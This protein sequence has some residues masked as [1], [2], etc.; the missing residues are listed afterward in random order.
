MVV[1][2]VFRD[3]VVGFCGGV[4]WWW[5]VIGWG[6]LR[7]VLQSGSIMVQVLMGLRGPTESSLTRFAAHDLFEPKVWLL[8]NCLL[9]GK[10]DRAFEQ[11]VG[12]LEWAVRELY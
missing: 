1:V 3:G 11:L 8:V 7:R 9:V 12:R 6:G 2:V 10:S 4:L 5:G